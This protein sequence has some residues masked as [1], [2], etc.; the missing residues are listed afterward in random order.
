MRIAAKRS[1]DRVAA[2]SAFGHATGVFFSFFFFFFFFFFFW[3]LLLALTIC[4]LC[5]NW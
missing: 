4:A 2:T 3:Q 5:N 1:I